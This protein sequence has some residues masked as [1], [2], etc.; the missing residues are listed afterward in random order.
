[1]CSYFIH[2]ADTPAE[3][4]YGRER[5]IAYFKDALIAAFPGDPRTA[6]PTLQ[7]FVK[8]VEVLRNMQPGDLTSN[9]M[10]VGSPQQI[11]DTLKTVEAAGISEVILYFNYG[12][13]PHAQVKE[14]MARFAEEIQPAFAGTVRVE[15]A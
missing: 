4:Q 3:E 14:Q 9:S 11:I 10:L 7:Y 5:L 15:S 2:I 6:P 8:I 1:M 13:K 12:L